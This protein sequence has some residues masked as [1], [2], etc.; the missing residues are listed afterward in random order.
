MTLITK[1]E[2]NQIVLRHCKATLE[3]Q[4]LVAVGSKLQV[5][6]DHDEKRKSIKKKKK[7]DSELLI[8]HLSVETGQ[9]NMMEKALPQRYD[10]QHDRREL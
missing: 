10:D 3:G 4:V 7:H 8:F 5:L 6:G 1:P 2:T 9:I